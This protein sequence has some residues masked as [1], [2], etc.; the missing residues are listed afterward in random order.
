[1]AGL[2]IKIEEEPRYL[3]TLRRTTNKEVLAMGDKQNY[4]FTHYIYFFMMRKVYKKV[5]ETVTY[6]GLMFI[7]YTVLSLVRSISEWKVKNFSF[8]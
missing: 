5:K 1:M 7:L 3:N 6:L 8:L 4:Y 2:Q